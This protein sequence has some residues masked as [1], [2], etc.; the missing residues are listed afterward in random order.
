VLCVS[1]SSKTLT[2]IAALG[3]FTSWF[4]RGD[5]IRFEELFYGTFSWHS[6]SV[7]QHVGSSQLTI[8]LLASVGS[9]LYI[10]TDESLD[11]APP[12]RYPQVADAA[13]EREFIAVEILPPEK[14]K[15][16]RPDDPPRLHHE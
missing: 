2:R 6:F 15:P 11:S 10:A 14:K 7:V 5:R 13:G 8:L 1:P 16:R 3:C 4:W 12:P 9:L